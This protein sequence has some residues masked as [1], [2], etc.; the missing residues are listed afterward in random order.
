MG[1]SLGAHLPERIMIVG[2]ETSNSYDFS[3]ELSAPVKAAVP[4]AVQIVLSLLNYQ[5]C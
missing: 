5:G 2:V 3:E 1:W 4:E